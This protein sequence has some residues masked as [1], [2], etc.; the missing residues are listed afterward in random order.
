MS[1]KIKNCFVVIPFV[2]S[3][4]DIRANENVRTE[5]EVERCDFFDIQ[6]Y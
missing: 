5:L 6:Q 2:S 1:F 4:Y 3:Y